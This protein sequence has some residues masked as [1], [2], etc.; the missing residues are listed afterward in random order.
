MSKNTVGYAEHL[1]DFS[2]MRIAGWNIKLLI[3]LILIFPL[4]GV[5]GIYIMV[6]EVVCR[7]YVYA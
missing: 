4:L 3:S 7:E 5:F 2:E 1:I 6:M